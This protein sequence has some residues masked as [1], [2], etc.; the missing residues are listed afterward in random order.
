MTAYNRN[1]GL[2]AIQGLS[3]FS[4]KLLALGVSHIRIADGPL[5]NVVENRT[6]A[7]QQLQDSM[8]DLLRAPDDKTNGDLV[9]NNIKVTLYGQSEGIQFWEFFN[10][11]LRL[12]TG[13]K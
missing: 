11:N 5:I 1:D 8:T 7:K 10:V 4:D 9:A 6:A 12:F 13:E 2:L 3:F